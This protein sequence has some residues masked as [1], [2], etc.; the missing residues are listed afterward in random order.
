MAVEDWSA[1]SQKPNINNNN[2]LTI[3]H[4]M[5]KNGHNFTEQYKNIGNLLTVEL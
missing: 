1:I 2:I 3:E 4:D 5:H